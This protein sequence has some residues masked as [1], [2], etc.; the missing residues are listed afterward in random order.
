MLAPSVFVRL[1]SFPAP[2]WAAL[3][4]K[5]GEAPK[6]APGWTTLAHTSINNPT[7]P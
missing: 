4:D 2:L 7:L 3:I 6:A 5:V 1:L